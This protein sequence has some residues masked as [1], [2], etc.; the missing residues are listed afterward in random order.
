MPYKTTYKM[1]SIKTNLIY[2]G[3]YLKHHKIDI[4]VLAPSLLGLSSL[5]ENVNNEINKGKSK[6]SIN[7]N[8]SVEQ[9]CFELLLHFDISIIEKFKNAIFDIEIQDI[10]TILILI[11]GGE[12]SFFELIKILKGKKIDDKNIIEKTETH[13]T[14]KG[15]IKIE[16]STVNIY[17]DTK[18]QKSAQSFI[19]PLGNKGIDEI[20][21]K[22]TALSKK[23]YEEYI[24]TDLN[25][26]EVN[27]IENKN[28]TTKNLVVF[29]PIFSI[30]K[31]YWEFKYGDN[32]MTVDI[33]LTRIAQDTLER[34]EVRIG[35][36]YKVKLEEQEY[37]T[38]TGI[39]KINYKII[40]VLDFKRGNIIQN[41]LNLDKK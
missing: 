13:T 14:I 12:I 15:G 5:I 39:Q 30:E 25:N 22:E 41:K 1:K 24:K 6:I 37:R 19:K 33:S 16:N 21:I 23:D 38:A 11:F 26:Y 27:K 7:V 20:K 32:I 2:D 18:I 28:I 29:R 31:K 4:N 40:E 8:A 35:D 9:N 17:N 34:G 36:T 3:E 10:E